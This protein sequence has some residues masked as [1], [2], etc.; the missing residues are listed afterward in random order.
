MDGSGID[1]GDDM[2]TGGTMVAVLITMLGS[3][4][5]QAADMP[6]LQVPDG[7]SIDV[8]ADDVPSARTVVVDDGGTVYVSSRGKG[9]VYALQDRDGDGHAETRYVLATGLHLPNGLALHDGALYVGETDRIR[10]WPDIANHL[11][12]PPP[13]VVVRDDLP[14]EAH[15]GSRYIAFGPDGKL[16]VAIGAPCN[17]CEA[18]TIPHD[19]EDLE[20]ASI[21]RMDADGSDWELVARGVRNSVGFD[22]NPKT[23]ELWFT[24]NGRDWLGDDLPSCELNKVSQLNQHYG[25]PYCHAGDIKD[26]EFGDKAACSSFVPPVAK[27]G[28]HVAPLGLK[29]ANRTSFPAVYKSGAFVALHGSWNRST[30][31]GYRVDWVGIDA[32]GRVTTQ[33]PFITGF[34]DGQEVRGR[35]VGFATLKD[36]SLLV[37]DD[38]AGKIYRVAYHGVS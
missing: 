8:W 37:S 27:L 24:E 10:K 14:K 3:A 36:G 32:Q 29:F 5:A 31:S 22:W 20:T 13:P 2:K 21:S 11:Q 23:G 4:R 34:L 19:P 7:F 33:T 12:S 28:A 26:P 38:Y 15:H 17:V 16:Y 6:P 9:E 30:K 35:P 1:G 18:K 25:F